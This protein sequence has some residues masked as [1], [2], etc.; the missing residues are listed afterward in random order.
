MLSI[1][2]NN[3]NDILDHK[4][5]PNNIPTTRNVEYFL[6]DLNEA[7]RNSSRIIKLFTTEYESSENFVSFILRVMIK[8][9][10]NE[11]DFKNIIP[12]K[13]LSIADFETSEIELTNLQQT[14]ESNKSMYEERERTM[15]GEIVEMRAHLQ[16]QTDKIRLQKDAL[17]KIAS[18]KFESD[19][20]IVTLT[21]DISNLKN[22]YISK[23]D[24]LVRLNKLLNDYERNIYAFKLNHAQLHNDRELTNEKYKMEYDNLLAKLSFYEN[25]MRMCELRKYERDKFHETNIDDYN[26]KIN[27]LTNR[28]NKIHTKNVNLQDKLNILKN[29][30]IMKNPE[31]TTAYVNAAKPWIG[32]FLDRRV[33]KLRDMNEELNKLNTVSEQTM[34][35]MNNRELD[36]LRLENE[37]NRRIISELRETVDGEFNRQEKN[38]SE[39]LIHP[40]RKRIDELMAELS[41]A[42]HTVESQRIVL[43]ENEKLLDIRQSQIDELTKQIGENTNFKLNNT[44]ILK[45]ILNDATFSKTDLQFIDREADFIQNS[46]LDAVDS[47]KSERDFYKNQVNSYIQPSINKKFILNDFAHDLINLRNV[48]EVRTALAKHNIID[49]ID[50]VYKLRNYF[51][52]Q[53]DHTFSIENLHKIVEKL[54]FDNSSLKNKHRTDTANLNDSRTTIGQLEHELTIARQGIKNLENELSNSNKINDNLVTSLREEI[55]KIN[56]NHKEMDQARL[57]IAAQLGE[58][59]RLNANNKSLF[60]EN[61]TYAARLFGKDSTQNGAKINFQHL[62]KILVSSK[63]DI[64]SD[65]VNNIFQNLITSLYGESQNSILINLN[66]MWSEFDKS[67]LFRVQHSSMVDKHGIDIMRENEFVTRT[68]ANLTNELSSSVIANEKI[69]ANKTIITDKLIGINKSDSYPL[70][71]IELLINI[72]NSLVTDIHALNFNEQIDTFV[73]YTNHYIELLKTN[74]II[75]NYLDQIIVNKMHFESMH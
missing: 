40:L 39:N 35:S 26:Y 50:T 27:S 52:K 64:L 11:L 31:T 69:I 30:F 38:V 23:A 14:I 59:D 58:I 8:L 5:T 53:F 48:N 54:Q 45:F 51:A 42:E 4:I 67:E 70:Y 65:S 49:F 25:Q 68:N 21:M 43:T 74:K 10:N 29:E 7:Y 6:N 61:E 18:E 66:N 75:G 17:K 28:V 73:Q 3:I 2:V 71:L 36:S 57:K 47:V 22:D 55:Q 60:D 12:N 9:N 37:H 20:K 56:V 24:E 44:L 41:R 34:T 1:F 16:N 15:N 62:V 46:I 32:L 19:Q 13:C 63:P 72:L 33:G